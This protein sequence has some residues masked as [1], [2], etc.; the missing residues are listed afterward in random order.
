MNTAA[1]W[2]DTT[3]RL[4]RALSALRSGPLAVDTEA[5]SLHHYPEKV[6]LIQLS[7]E[8]RNFLVDPLA[9]LSL[10]PLAERLRDARLVKVLHG[11]DYDVRMLQRGFGMDCRG[12]F[13]TMI[14]ARLTGETRFG[15]AALLDK[16]FGVPMDKRFQ[17]AD[18]S[19]RPLTPEMTHYATMDTH[20]LAGLYERLDS[21]LT[22]LGRRAWA[23]EEFERLEKVRPA[24]ARS[25]EDGFRRV[26]GCGKLE[27]R[28][29]AVLRELWT[30]RESRA[31]EL[32][33]PP[34]RVMHDL[35]LVALSDVLPVDRT[36]LEAVQGLPRPWRQGRRASH[37]LEAI[38]R[39]LNV[40]PEA[41]PARSKKGR[42]RN[43]PQAGGARL[44]ALRAHRD[45]VAAELGLDPALLG[46]RAVL[47]QIAA[48]VE[49]GGD[50][51]SVP[52][53]RRWQWG[54]LAPGLEHSCD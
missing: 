28:K 34:F 51:A 27:R 40:P 24:P 12:L 42:T 17:R 4:E 48:R 26:K 7:L 25:A 21:R 44:D 3:D 47:E 9:S 46:P 22:E 39:G 5:D 16:H 43:P 54:L 45:H 20:Y 52:E 15:L 6:C 49:E 37:L 41:W 23:Q 32:D 38:H 8:G 2:I 50:P 11:A 18:W 14:A 19:V 35:V 29:L 31:L 13:D 30:L 36:E 1:E 10:D 33:R 53:L